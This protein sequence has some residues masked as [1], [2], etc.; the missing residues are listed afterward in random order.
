MKRAILA[1][2]VLL[3]SGVTH[4]AVCPNSVTLRLDS[5]ECPI[6]STCTGKEGPLT[7]LEHDQNLA[8]VAAICL[9]ADGVTGGSG[10]S[11]ILDLAD[12]GTNE[13]TAL[14]EIAVTNDTG[15]AFTE[16]SADKLLIDVSKLRP[17]SLLNP[18][19]TPHAYD[20]EFD[21]GL[22]AGWSW[23]SA[24]TSGT[25]NP[26]SAPGT[27]IYDTATWPGWVLVQAASSYTLRLSASL[28]GDW[29]AWTHS[30]TQD[31]TVGGSSPERR[32]GVG[33]WNSSDTNESF[34]CSIVTNGSGAFRLQLLVQNNGSYSAQESHTI[35][36]GE[37]LDPIIVLWKQDNG[38]T[39]ALWCAVYSPFGG[40]FIIG[41]TINKTGTVAMD[42]LELYL[43]GDNITPLPIV[44]ADYIRF[45][46]QLQ[47]PEMN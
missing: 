39:D 47:L 5:S 31:T 7:L 10:T 42:T 16:P 1:I 29:T 21:S 33:A 26:L 13:S 19:V 45:A 44:G 9:W 40:S 18:R 28:D 46:A 38:S 2:V 37:F 11:V 14:A 41:S 24:P 4:A 30:M 22:C 6:G 23:A 15:A 32:I 25:V 12:D 8:N 36:D 3:L 27:D 35:E 20:C 34:A 43:Y 17:R